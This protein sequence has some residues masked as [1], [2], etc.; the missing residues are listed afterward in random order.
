MD[1]EEKRKQLENLLL[2]NTITREEF[3]K[4][5]QELTIK[6]EKQRKI[7]DKKTKRNKKI[8]I[9]CVVF[10]FLWFIIRTIIMMTLLSQK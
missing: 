3:D 10:M 9:V 6:E 2:A 7:I 8:L 5:L 1:F 4:K